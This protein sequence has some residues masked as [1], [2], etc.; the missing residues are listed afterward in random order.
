MTRETAFFEGWSSF[1][2]NNFEL[3]LSA[4]LK[5][6]NNAS[7]GLKIKVRKFWGLI[8]TFVEDTEEKLVRG[9]FLVAT[10]L[11]RVKGNA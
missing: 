11:N 5:F 6:Y 1:K 10:M 3:A 2:F 8:P 4:S 7:K 9:P